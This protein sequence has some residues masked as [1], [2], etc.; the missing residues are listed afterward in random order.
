MQNYTK[1]TN[2]G[3]VLSSYE[4]RFYKLKVGKS[5]FQDFSFFVTINFSFFVTTNFSRC[6]QFYFL[7]SGFAGAN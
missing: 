6:Q 5:D 2:L 7:Q 3:A 1:I 4:S